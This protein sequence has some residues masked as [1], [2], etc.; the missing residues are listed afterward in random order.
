[1]NHL[2][3][4]QNVFKS[5]ESINQLWFDGIE[6]REKTIEEID[7]KMSNGYVSLKKVNKDESKLIYILFYHPEGEFD[8]LISIDLLKK[9]QESAI[10]FQMQDKSNYPI[11]LNEMDKMQIKDLFKEFTDRLV[12]SF[13]NKEKA[14][15]EGKKLILG[16]FKQSIDNDYIIPKGQTGVHAPIIKPRLKIKPEIK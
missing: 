4:W 9:T 8:I 5:W 3:F 14:I 16:Y 2:N 1:M 15:K 13:E 11:H 10:N 6:L 12:I 7:L